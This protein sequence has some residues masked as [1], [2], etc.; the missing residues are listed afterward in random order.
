ML[1]NKHADPSRSWHPFFGDNCMKKASIVLLLLAQFSAY[2]QNVGVQH[3]IEER[4]DTNYGWWVLGVLLILAA[5]IGLY[6][7]IK[8][9]PRKDA[10]R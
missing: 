10:V 4:H 8:K 2:T 7:F 3:P 5:G 9:D 6:M 1:F